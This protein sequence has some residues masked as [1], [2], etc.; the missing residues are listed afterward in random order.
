M[1]VALVAQHAKRMRFHLS[2]VKLYH[3]FPRYFINIMIRENA[4]EYKTCVL[5]FATTS[6][7]NSSH[8]TTNSVRWP[9]M[10]IDRH[11]QY[12]LFLS[13]FNETSWE[14]VQW[15]P[16]CS[17]RTHTHTHTHTDEE[18][19]LTVPCRNFAN[20][21]WACAVFYCHLWPLWCYHIFPHCLTNGNFRGKKKLW[22]TKCV[23]W[24]SLQLLSDDSQY[25][26]LM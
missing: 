6:E 12:T 17:M 4:T 2:P 9:R 25:L 13:D 26:L 15:E 1:S 11:V 5:I 19:K 16:S 18:T 10:Y 24:F 21:Q 14:S 7:R 3:I 8:S 22:N 23:F 20:T